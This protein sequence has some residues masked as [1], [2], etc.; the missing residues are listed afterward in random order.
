MD[1]LEVDWTS[2]ACKR[3]KKIELGAAGARQ[4]WQGKAVLSRLGIA[5]TEGLND[6]GNERKP[7]FDCS[8]LFRRALS[9]RMDLS[10]RF[11]AFW[12]TFK[13]CILKFRLLFRRTLCNLPVRELIIEHCDDDLSLYKASVDLL[14]K[15]RDLVS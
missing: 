12:P 5:H 11:V 1:A 3:E 15:D 4:S 8:S 6:V 7:L 13:F 14:L 2:L 10:F 9:A